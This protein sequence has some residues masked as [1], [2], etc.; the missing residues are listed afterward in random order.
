M[1][2]TIKNDYISAALL[3]KGAELCGLYYKE[4][5]YMWEGNP[6][7]WAKHA[8]VLFPIVGTLKNNTYTIDNK[9][10][11][12]PRH[13]FA[14]DYIFDIKAHASDCI[15]FVLQ[16][17]EVTQQMYPFQFLFEISYQL[18]DTKLVVSYH[19]LNN[20]VTPMPFCIGGHPAFALPL[21]FENYSLD[22][23][24]NTS[25]TTF[26]L[27]NDLLSNTTKTLQLDQGKLPLNYNLFENDALVIKNIPSKSVQITENGTPF[28]K[29]DYTDFPDL[30]I[31][32]KVDAPFICIEPWFGYADTPNCTGNLFEKEGIIILK[33][34]QAFKASFEVE[35]F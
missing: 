16:A 14:R 17:N 9:E 34:N 3:S 35:V 26:L 2:I 23:Q 1:N 27:D 29:L 10:F 24:Q 18:I 19:V 33:P 8:P 15:V 32:T 28:L 4:R 6:K 12:L 31:W 22:F 20:D 13:G 25:L 30:G 11:N 7:F 21:D 5:N